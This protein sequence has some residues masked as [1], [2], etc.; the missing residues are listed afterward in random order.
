MNKNNKKIRG[1][2]PEKVSSWLAVELKELSTPPY[3]FELIA[4]GGSN[5]TYKI[6][7]S[8]G[9]CFALRRPPEVVALH[10][11]HDMS[12]EWRIMS[13]LGN[14]EKQNKIPVPECL[15]Y[16]KDLDILGAEFYVMS[17]VEGTILRDSSTVP[18]ITPE[19]A[20]AAT[21][22]LIEVQVLMHTL[23]LGEAN[24]ADLA[25][26]E[27]YAGRQLKRWK[28][29]V[30]AGGIR[31]L[32]LHTELY[33]RLLK[34]KPLE[35]VPAGLVHGDYRFDNCVLDSSWNIAAVLDWELC[36]LGNP[37]ADF[38]WSLQYWAD[39][40]DEMKWLIDSPTLNPS[41]MRREEYCNLYR[42]ISRFNLADMDYYT[43]F[44]WWK[45]ASI[46]E[47]VYARL[48][49]GGGGGMS[50]PDQTANIARRVDDMLDYAADLSEGVLP[51]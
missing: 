13:A 12:R 21:E 46:V 34:S 28:R 44:S 49:A 7:D 35:T 27:D 9:S 17:F 14:S 8:A 48:L 23:D 45:Q 30:E 15:A 20:R 24:L 38:V 11:A 6:T 5:L 37:I 25:K 16:S 2:D 26:H 19:A 47:G 10:S 4:A 18:D 42:R 29:Q 43:V 3:E 22:S 39:P 50:D 41:F 40:G 33:E 51:A 1:L 31:D 32:P 36:T